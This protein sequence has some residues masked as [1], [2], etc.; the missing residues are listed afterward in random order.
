[1]SGWS[2]GGDTESQSVT[3]A[4]WASRAINT[5]LITQPE[6]PE[7]KLLC[8]QT[9]KVAA[10]CVSVGGLELCVLCFSRCDYVA[11]VLMNSLSL[12]LICTVYLY[13]QYIHIYI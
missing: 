13:V 9:H 10:G 8:D 5:G 6:A 4:C 11:L 1:M 2:A 7:L 3:I 12:S